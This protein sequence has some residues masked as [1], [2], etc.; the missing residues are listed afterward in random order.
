MLTP[1]KGI[2]T[3]GAAA[4]L[5]GEEA[6]FEY[7]VAG[8]GKPEFVQEVLAKFPA[9]KTTYLGW[10]DPN[11]FYPSIDVL[12]VPSISGE[13]FGYVC[14]EALSFGIP[15]IVAKSGALP[16]IIDHGR[17]GL[18]F[19]PGDHEALAVCLRRLAGDRPLL[20]Q[21]HYAA[22]ARV[23]QYSPEVMAASLDTFLTQVRARAQAKQLN[24]FASHP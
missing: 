23:E 22:L 18:V 9:S 7:V 1:N 11:S 21:F 17:C 4:A 12:V 8:D 3:I 5:L 6:P 15:V 2:S 16:E 19:N 24:V 14:I 13:A 10:V 20:K